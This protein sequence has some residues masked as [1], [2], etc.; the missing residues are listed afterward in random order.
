MSVGHSGLPSFEFA[1]LRTF[2]ALARLAN[3]SRA[4]DEMRLS[5]SGVSRRIRLLEESLGLRLFERIGRRA[6]LTSAG[7]T[8]CTRLGTLMREA[9]TLPRLLDD[10]AEGVRGELRVGAS[11][12]AAN[13]LLPPV[14]GLYRQQYPDVE[15]ALQPGGSTSILDTLR[16]GELDLAFV[17]L[18]ALP[19]DF[20]V[21]GEIPDKVLLFAAPDHPL[22]R[23]RATAEALQG[24]DFIHREASSETRQLVTRWL[25]TKRIQVRT[26]MD[27]W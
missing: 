24:A 18:E 19:S 11:I 8:L 14:L 16:R 2:L 23:K 27:V 1:H 22:S 5:Q 6:V 9:E 17:A 10:L 12:T 7:R 21:L 4:A 26:L 13:A 25:E 15:L 3:F 20:M